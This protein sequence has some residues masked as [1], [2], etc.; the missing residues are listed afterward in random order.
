MGDRGESV[1]RSSAATRLGLPRATICQRTLPD[2]PI[3][4][5]ATRP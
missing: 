2:S 5:S 1:P 3:D 4:Q